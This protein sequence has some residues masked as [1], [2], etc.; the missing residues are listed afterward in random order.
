MQQAIIVEEERRINSDDGINEILKTISQSAGN[1]SMENMIE[2]NLLDTIRESAYTES[3]NKI[4]VDAFVKAKTD[5]LKYM[6][7][8]DILE[9]ANLSNEAHQQYFEYYLKNIAEFSNTSRQWY[10]AQSDEAFF[11]ILKGRIESSN[12]L[13]Q[14]K[15][16]IYIC[17][18][19]AIN[20]LP[21]LIPF[22]DQIENGQ[23][24]EVNYPLAKLAAQWI[25]GKIKN[26][27]P[28]S[29]HIA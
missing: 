24:I 26:E 1:V 2:N 22:L 9:Y 10:K 23:I 28:N 8:W 5:R 29:I 6:L 27:K 12:G 25:K 17:D 3:V 18:L 19:Y 4:L 15:K 20:Q 16:W 21:E 14:K 13:N 7:L 11:Q